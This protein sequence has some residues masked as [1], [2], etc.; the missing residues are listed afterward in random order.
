MINFFCHLSFDKGAQ[1]I[2][3]GKNNLFN[4]LHRDDLMSPYLL[5]HTKIN[6][7]LIMDFN[8]RAKTTNA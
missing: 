4:K 8:G 2:L 3:W 1:T 5:P 6:S 7:K